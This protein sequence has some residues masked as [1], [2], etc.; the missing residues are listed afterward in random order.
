VNCDHSEDN[1]V[2]VR[3]C[4]IVWAVPSLTSNEMLTKFACSLTIGLVLNPEMGPL[5]QPQL[6]RMVIGNN[7]ALVGW[8][9]TRKKR[10][11]RRMIC[12]SVTF[13]TI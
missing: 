13:S 2:Q 6:M 3:E 5:Y 10:S 8:L 9:L 7:K 1:W 12:P 4:R 11:A